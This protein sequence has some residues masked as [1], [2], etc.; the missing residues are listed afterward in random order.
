PPRAK[1]DGLESEDG[2]GVVGGLEEPKCPGCSKPLAPDAVVCTACGFDRRTGKKPEKVYEPLER[3]FEAGWP[4]RTR[5]VRCSAFEA[6]TLSLGL[7][8]AVMI[9]EVPGFL[10]CWVLATGMAAFLIGTFDRVDLARN[11]RGKVTLT[12]TWRACFIPQAT[13]SIR[14]SEYEGVVSC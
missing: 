14:V 8:C 11:R 13:Q 9:D 2:Y 6:V 1:G 7:A 3:T 12:R 10:F 5:V 4:L